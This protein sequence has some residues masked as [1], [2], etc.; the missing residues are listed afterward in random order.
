LEQKAN[1]S[2]SYC[3]GLCHMLTD[4][5]FVPGRETLMSNRTPVLSRCAA[6]DELRRNPPDERM[7]RPDETVSIEIVSLTGFIDS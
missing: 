6:G 7:R 4:S 2:V 1:K 3:S 5:R